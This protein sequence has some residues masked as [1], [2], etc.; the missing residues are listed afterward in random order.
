MDL[1]YPGLRYV[2]KLS[3]NLNVFRNIFSSGLYFQKEKLERWWNSKTSNSG[4]ILRAPLLTGS[5][6]GPF[7]SQTEAQRNVLPMVMHFTREWLRPALL[8]PISIRA[9]APTPYCVLNP[10]CKYLG[11]HLLCSG[12]EPNWQY[13]YLNTYTVERMITRM[14]SQR[15]DETIPLVAW[16]EEI[17]SATRL[18]KQMENYATNSRQPIQTRIW[19]KTK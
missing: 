5:P 4:Y 19:R 16:W 10:V 18:P 15:S 11:L 14:D 8:L 9:L 1:L 12:S 7:C 2:V 3:I 6:V 13:E 17:R